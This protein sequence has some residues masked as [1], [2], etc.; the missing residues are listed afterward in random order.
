MTYIYLI[1]LYGVELQ[2]TNLQYGRHKTYN[3]IDTKPTYNVGH[4]MVLCQ[5]ILCDMTWYDIK[6]IYLI[7]LY[8]V[9]LQKGAVGGAP[10]GR[11]IPTN[12]I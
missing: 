4:T 12:S 10:A 3:M 8:G 1:V 6:V 2:K 7:V 11:P 9:E 5:G